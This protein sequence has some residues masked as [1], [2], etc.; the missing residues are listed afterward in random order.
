MALST[1]KGGEGGGGEFLKKFQL[2][3]IPQGQPKDQL[4]P[5]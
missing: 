3:I 2:L 5:H 1:S 4:E